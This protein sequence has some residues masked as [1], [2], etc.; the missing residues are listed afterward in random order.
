MAIVETKSYS[1]RLQ[2]RGNDVYVAGRRKT[3]STVEEARREAVAVNVALAGQL[4]RRELKV[5]PILCVHRADLPLFGASLAGVSIVDAHG[6]VKLL[7][8]A[9]P[10]LSAK[11]VRELPRI[12]ND[13]LRPA[14]A[15]LPPRHEAAPVPP[16][17]DP[18][19]AL[20]ADASSAPADDEQFMPPVG[21]E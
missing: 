6:L 20:P 11:D 8:E 21:L 3:L 4:D 5:R 12:T 17:S 13:R 19:V 15:R 10:R 2:V 1:G 16:G 14:V 7:R 9:P 18:T